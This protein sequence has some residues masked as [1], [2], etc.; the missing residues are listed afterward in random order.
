M[1]EVNRFQALSHGAQVRYMT[2]NTPLKECLVRLCQQKKTALI[3][4]ESCTHMLHCIL[5]FSRPALHF[6]SLEL[7]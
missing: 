6:P 1:C 3:M 5:G 2:D 4:L 7:F